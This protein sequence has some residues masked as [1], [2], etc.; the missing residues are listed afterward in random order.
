[1]IASHQVELYGKSSSFPSL[2]PQPKPG[3]YCGSP[4]RCNNML[5]LERKVR[6][7]FSFEGTVIDLASGPY[8]FISH[9]LQSYHYLVCSGEKNPL[10]SGVLNFG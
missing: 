4:L 10:R 3:S 8:G 9:S 2:S 5:C 1:M 7:F 6:L